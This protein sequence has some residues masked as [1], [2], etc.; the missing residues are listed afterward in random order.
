VGRFSSSC[1]PLK[2]TRALCGLFD[3]LE[4]VVTSTA[5]TLLFPK[6]ADGIKSPSGEGK[7]MLFR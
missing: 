2:V 3:E 1:L 4:K 7:C 6:E 5:E